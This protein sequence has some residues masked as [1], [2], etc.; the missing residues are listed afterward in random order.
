MEKKKIRPDIFDNCFHGTHYLD[1]GE[2]YAFDG[3]TRYSAFDGKIFNCRRIKL[4]FVQLI[5]YL[6]FY[7]PYNIC[8]HALNSIIFIV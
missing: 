2:K 8:K 1:R 4:K 5:T 7:I 6:S 3:L